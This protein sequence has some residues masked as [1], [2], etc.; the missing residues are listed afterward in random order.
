MRRRAFLA[1]LAASTPFGA[2]A[3]TI[4]S[5]AEALSGDRFAVD[6]AEFI[7]ADILAPPLYTLADEAPA[8][9]EASRRALQSAMAGAV[10]I[11][12]V[13]PATRWG[14]RI[15]QARRSGAQETLQENAV[16][17]G[18]A[19]V[20][21][22]SGDHVFIRRLLELEAEARA[23]RRGLWALEDYRIFDAANA[24]GAVG[25]FHLVEGT[26]VRA[27]Q[28]G[29]RF[30]LN[31]GEDYRTDFTA[32]ATLALYPRWAKAGDDLA[33]Y[34]NAGIRVRGLVEPINGPSL[35]LKHPLQI[36]R[37]N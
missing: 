22:Q 20:G 1:G 6:G 2:S 7:L 16:A 24:W 19:R 26:V 3:R 36:E 28:F 12:D 27:A 15:I 25:G 31:F 37:L 14:G 18:A 32:G 8:Y 9:F 35:D 21:P 29:G 13:L 17:A 10:E 34:E 11:E 33:A 30:Y 23:A 4:I 5:N